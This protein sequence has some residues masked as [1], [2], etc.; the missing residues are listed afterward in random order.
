[1]ADAMEGADAPLTADSAGQ[2]GN[3]LSETP[4]AN[5]PVFGHM[6]ESA[7]KAVASG[8]TEGVTGGKGLPPVTAQTDPIL[9]E[10]QL[11]PESIDTENVDHAL[12]HIDEVSTLP[13]LSA[14][15][16]MP[17]P[18]APSSRARPSMNL[19]QD[20]TPRIHCGNCWH[21][22][23]SRRILCFRLKMPRN[24]SDRLKSC[25]SASTHLL[26]GHI[27]RNHCNMNC[28]FQLLARHILCCQLRMLCRNNGSLREMQTWRSRC[29]MA[30]PIPK[31]H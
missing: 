6:L 30:G 17:E 8:D 10:T 27:P 2:S 12:Q 7:R 5:T 3:L 13:M 26:P 19:L 31:V 22:C 1:M 18:A 23:H 9:P 14:M 25:F 16:R 24:R 11:L 20:R 28:R 4:D 29:S 15:S 21:P